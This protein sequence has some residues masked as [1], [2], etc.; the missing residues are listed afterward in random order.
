MIYVAPLIFL[1]IA[2]S[3]PATYLS[4]KVGFAILSYARETPRGT[5]AIRMGAC[6]H[7][8]TRN[9]PYKQVRYLSRLFLMSF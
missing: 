1:L 2:V 8:L 5:A 7:G 3:F 6:A 4:F 9:P